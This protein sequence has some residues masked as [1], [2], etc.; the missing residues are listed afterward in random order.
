MFLLA[1]FCAAAV[2][3]AVSEETGATELTIVVAPNPV[4]KPV[5]I[6]ERLEREEKEDVVVVMV[7]E[8]E[9]GIEETCCWAVVEETE[10]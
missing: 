9:R 4:L 10:G 5:P 1:R 3:L 2:R 8:T 6:A 7:K